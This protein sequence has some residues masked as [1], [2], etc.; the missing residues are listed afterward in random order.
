MST[1]PGLPAA[2]FKFMD[3]LK[4]NNNRDWFNENKE[5]YYTDVADPVCDF[6]E[7]IAPTPGGYIRPLHCRLTHSRRFHVPHLP[8]CTLHKR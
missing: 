5:R 1:Y 6:I 2:L 3:Q 7:A 8:R 4:R